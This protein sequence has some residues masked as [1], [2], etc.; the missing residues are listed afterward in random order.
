MKALKGSAVI[1]GLAASLL[2]TAPSLATAKPSGHLYGTTGACNNAAPGGPCTQTSTLVELDPVTGALLRTVGPVGYT[3]NGLAWDQRSKRLYGSTAIGD[4][5]FHGLVTIDP[6]TGAGTPV[7]PHV[8]NF[9]LP[10]PDSPI[11]SITI[12]SR[13]RMAGWYDEFPP[14]ATV[15]DT[16]V[17]I[18][19]ARGVATEH[20]ATG[21]NTSQ[22]GLSFDSDDELW[23]IDAPSS[24]AIGAPATQ[25]AYR[26]SAVDG[27]VLGTVDITPPTPAA[28]G[29]FSP[30][31]RLY[32]GLRFE[33]FSPT[34][35]TTIE[36]VD[37]G[38]GTLTTL[39][40]TVDDLHTLAFS[41]NV[42]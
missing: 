21:I 31:T 24:K 34:R 2:V 16:F 28:L 8:S 11:H 37:V 26:L 22:N 1:A 36:V 35:A 29:D 27:R 12:D 10:G 18:D 39:G 6:V 25:T 32:Y 15:T 30:G 9:G 5:A 23:N 3:I 42:K 38:T 17:T 20:P 13:G 7:G 41:K 40:R 4:V 33:P 19:K 14:P